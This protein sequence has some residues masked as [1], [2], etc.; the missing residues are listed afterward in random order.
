M[1]QPQKTTETKT[2]ETKTTQENEKVG[3]PTPRPE[4][5]PEREDRTT[6]DEGGTGFYGPGHNEGGEGGVS[7]AKATKRGA[8][9]TS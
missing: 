7:G 8:G 1:T 6:G 5:Q 3:L 2:T 9:K 4:G